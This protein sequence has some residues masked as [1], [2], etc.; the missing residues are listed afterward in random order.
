MTEYVNA[1]PKPQ[2]GPCLS[3]TMHI[4][5]IE[6]GVSDPPKGIFHRWI[7]LSTV[8]SASI[9]ALSARMWILLFFTI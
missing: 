6:S 9:T 4:G 2:R 1:H 8:A 7:M 3:P 5:S